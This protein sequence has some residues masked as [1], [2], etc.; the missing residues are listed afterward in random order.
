MRGCTR[1][2]MHITQQQLI[3]FCRRPEGRTDGLDAHVGA[4]H[5]HLGQL[6]LHAHLRGPQTVISWDRVRDIPGLTIKSHRT[7]KAHC[8]LYC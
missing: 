5:Q 8:E 1:G 2:C 6:V 3:S 7:R 4:V